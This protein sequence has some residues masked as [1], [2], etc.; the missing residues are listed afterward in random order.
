MVVIIYKNLRKAE[1]PFSVVNKFIYLSLI[2]VTGNKCL[3]DLNKRRQKMLKFKIAI[4]TATMILLSYLDTTV[5][6][7]IRNGLFQE[8]KLEIYETSQGIISLEKQYAKYFINDQPYTGYVTFGDGL[9]YFENGQSVPYLI[10]EQGFEV[11]DREGKKL[12]ENR[13]NMKNIKL[14]IQMLE[15]KS[16][17]RSFDD[18]KIL[19]TD[20]R[21][22]YTAIQIYAEKNNIPTTEL[23]AMF[24][25]VEKI[26]S[27]YYLNF[28]NP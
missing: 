21:F 13:M 23:E 2:I 25:W 9:H 14:A 6:A 24:L 27:F 19:F 8:Q 20:I 5:Y 1:T 7:D 28:L 11:Y 4:I 12:D 3:K 26:G 22:A 10:T 17:N 16:N 18:S 15:Q